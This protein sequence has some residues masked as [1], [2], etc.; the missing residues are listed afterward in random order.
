[1]ERHHIIYKSQLG[2]DFPMNYKYLSAM[3][4]R[5][6]NGPH[7]DRE[8]DLKYKRELEQNLIDTLTDEKYR[9]DELIEI[10]ELD[11]EQAYKSFKQVNKT[12]KGMAREDIIKRLLGGR[13]YIGVD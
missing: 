9:V 12:S 13:F 5:G 4:H 3:D 11:D 10:L 8:T 7:M 6:N 1:M 2:L